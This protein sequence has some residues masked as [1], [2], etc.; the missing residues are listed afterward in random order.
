VHRAY[1]TRGYLFVR[2]SPAPALDDATDRMTIHVTVSEGAQYHMGT[3]AFTGIDGKVAAELQKQW[4]LK[5]GAV[6]DG[7]YLSRFMGDEI[8]HRRGLGVVPQSFRPHVT[9][10]EAAHV[11]NVTFSPE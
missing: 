4:K 11:V 7:L 9:P 6:Y 5:P 10:D 1:L 3:L 2:L 8:E